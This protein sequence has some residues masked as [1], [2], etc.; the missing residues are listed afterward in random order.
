MLIDFPRQ[1]WLRERASMLRH[2]YIVF[3]MYKNLVKCA[4][5]RFA[6]H[7]VW[8]TITESYLLDNFLTECGHCAHLQSSDILHAQNN[9]ASCRRKVVLAGRSRKIKN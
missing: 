1:Q 4:G 7:R 3:V 2:T 8:R 5:V 9:K 6:R